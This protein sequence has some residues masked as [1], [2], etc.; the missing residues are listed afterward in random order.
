MQSDV[1]FETFPKLGLQDVLGLSLTK[2]GFLSSVPYLCF[3]VV[4]LVSGYIADEARSRGHKT[5]GRRA[6]SVPPYCTTRAVTSP[7]VSSTSWLTSAKWPV[8]VRRQLP[9]PIDHALMVM[10]AEPCSPK[11]GAALDYKH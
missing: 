6:T 1:V 7:S 4:A 9:W 11:L 2:L 3:F 10:S 5:V 8:R